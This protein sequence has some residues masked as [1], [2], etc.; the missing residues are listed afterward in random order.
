MPGTIRSISL[1]AVAALAVLACSGT[2]ASS[3]P[4]DLASAIPSAAAS[5]AASTGASSASATRVSAND[6]THDELVAALTNAGVA[7]ADRWAREIEEYRPYDTSDATLQKLQDNL[8][9]YD[10]SPETLAGILTAL[11]P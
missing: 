2:G 8:A 7:N 3:A 6:A 5:T 1:T 4:S 9:K 10:P 11:Q